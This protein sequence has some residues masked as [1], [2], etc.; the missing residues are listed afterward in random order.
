M[1]SSVVFQGIE[2][3]SWETDSIRQEKIFLAIS[4]TIIGRT[5]EDRLDVARS[6]VIKI[7]LEKVH[8]DQ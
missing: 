1:E 6:K 7:L 8:T 2:E 3:S 4:E 5:L